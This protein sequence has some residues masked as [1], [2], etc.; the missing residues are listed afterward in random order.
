MPALPNGF[1]GL[2]RDLMHSNDPEAN[3]GYIK[4]RG[5]SGVGHP[6]CS[7]NAKTDVNPS[8]AEVVR[9]ISPM[10]F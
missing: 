8:P 2:P 7:I 9:R 10:V 4:R 5:L 6:I 1:C 3:Y